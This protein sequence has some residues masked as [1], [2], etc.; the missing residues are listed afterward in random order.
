MSEY[1]LA[2]VR[3]VEP[4]V[5]TMFYVAA[6]RSSNQWIFDIKI[7]RAD[8]AAKSNMTQHEFKPLHLGI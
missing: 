4:L 7:L 3:H 2:F 6:E 5:S 8:G 1:R